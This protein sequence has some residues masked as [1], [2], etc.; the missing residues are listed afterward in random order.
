MNTHIAHSQRMTAARSGQNLLQAASGVQPKSLWK[1]L[2][3]NAVSAEKDKLVFAD[4]SVLRYMGQ[5]GAYLAS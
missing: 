1:A 3:M 5:P 2:R 4:G